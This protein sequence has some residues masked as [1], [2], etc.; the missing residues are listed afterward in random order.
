MIAVLG[1]ALALVAGPL[2]AAPPIGTTTP[3][4]PAVGPQL[5]DAAPV[6]VGSTAPAARAPDAQ[7]VDDFSF[8]SFD[9]DYYLTRDDDGFSRLRTVETLVADFP[10]Y[11][12][13]RGIVRA[14]PQ[15]YDGADLA[16]QVISVTD[17]DGEPV[18]HEESTDDGFLEVATGTDDFVRGRQTYVITYDQRNVTRSYDDTAA[19]EFYWDTNGT[20]WDQPFGA[21]TTRVHVPSELADALTGSTACYVGAESDGT[22]CAI[23]DAAEGAADVGRVVVTASAFDLGP[24]ENV[25]VAIGF[26]RGTFTEAPRAVDQPWVVVFPAVVA[27]IAAAF[28]AVVGVLRL[29]RWRDARGRRIVVAQYERPDG[30]DLL[31]AGEVL[32][33]TGQ[34]TSALLVDLAV[35]GNLRIVDRTPDDL[36][37]DA[38]SLQFVSRRRP[39]RARTRRGPRHLRHEAEAGQAPKGRRLRGPRPGARRA[40]VEDTRSRER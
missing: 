21:V 35:R 27:V 26:D 30:V 34:S 11:D 25:T 14:I 22:E 10:D 2:L 23:D 37:D 17:S 7:T 20:G 39:L 32:R 40:G 4:P 5:L 3:A 6:P 13:N 8:E 19:D 31:E 38:Y 36:D 33:R 15:R 12:Q 29:R 16:P 24:G 28:A 18:P 1:A 9:A